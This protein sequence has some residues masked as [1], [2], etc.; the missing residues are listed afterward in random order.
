MRRVKHERRSLSLLLCTFWINSQDGHTLHDHGICGGARG[1]PL[2][3]V[4]RH[5][6]ASLDV[7]KGI[8]TLRQQRHHS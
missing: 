1:S 4:D 3:A 7:S 5:A 8:P 6:R 2:S